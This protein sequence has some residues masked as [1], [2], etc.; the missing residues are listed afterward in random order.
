MEIEV[1]AL[2]K[3]E[4]RLSAERLAALQSELAEQKEAFQNR[5]LCDLCH[6]LVLSNHPLVQLL[7]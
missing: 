4:D 3:E 2:K 7:I 1:A 6:A 5:R